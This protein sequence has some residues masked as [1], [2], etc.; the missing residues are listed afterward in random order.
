MKKI[1]LFSIGLIL[2]Q[3]NVNFSLESKF[4]DGLSIKNS[5][6]TEEP[7]N[8]FENLLDVNIQFISGVSLWTQLEYSDPPVFGLPKDGLN[9]FY[10]EFAN[11][12]V[13]IK[14][15][16]IYTLYGNGL[17]LNLVIDQNVDLDNSIKGLEFNFYTSDQLRLYSL[18]GKGRFEFTESESPARISSQFRNSSG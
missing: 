5:G 7:Y 14:A 16:D 3:T 11:D 18:I 15:G 6:S 1:L 8:Y 17:G 9:K 2:S 13:D 12:L 4:G 10:F